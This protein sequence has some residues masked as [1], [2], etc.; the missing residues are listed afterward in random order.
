MCGIAGIWWREGADELSPSI[1]R[2]TDAIAHRG[3]D[4]D[5]FW[6]DATRGLAFGHRR[7]SIL[8]LSAAGAQPMRSASGRYVITFNGEIYNFEAIRAELDKSFRF[9]WSGGSDT[10]VMLAAIEAWG[11]EKAL[12]RF[13][14]MFAFGLWDAERRQLHLVRDRFGV[15]PLYVAELDNGIA[16][17]SELKA[18]R[19][20][21]SFA[22]TTDPDAISRYFDRSV[23]PAPRT[24]YANAK[25]LMPGTI[26]TFVGPR[27]EARTTTT[28]WSAEEVARSGVANLMKGADGEVVER[29]EIALREAVE[30]RL[31]SDVPL[32][33]FLSGGIDSSLVVALMQ[34]A[35]AKRVRTFSIGYSDATYDEGEDAARV[36]AHLGTDHTAFTLSP[37][38][39]LAVV[40]KLASMYDEPF[41]DS[42]QIPTHLVSALARKHVTVALSGD[43]GDEV[44]GGYNRHIWGPRLWSAMRGVPEAWRSK[45]S[46]AMKGLKTNDLQRVF[47]AAMPFLPKAL[48]VRVAGD[49]VRKVAAVLGATSPE[50]IY[51]ILTAYGRIAESPLT[52]CR[53]VEGDPLPMMPNIEDLFMLSDVLDALPDDILTKVDR[54]SM[55]VSLE[56]REPLLDHRLYALA[57]RLPLRMKIRDGRGK[58]V[59]R[60]VLDR[61]VPRSL[62]DRPKMGFGVPIGAWLRGPLRAWAEERLSEEA[63]RADGVF[64]VPR[65]RGYWLEHLDGRRDRTHSLWDILMFVEWR[66]LERST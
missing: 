15:K 43:G 13:V 30:A 40:P 6:I 21:K 31:V 22:R 50:H 39:A 28:Y 27:A 62:V 48:R 42:S 5:G 57:W 64:D 36:A 55:A 8:D 38:D 46:S 34:R 19:T 24:I 63:L 2:M 4:A 7:L 44:F 33:A 52:D 60:E 61:Y 32:G 14:G 11:L 49:K 37:E 23:I 1:Q 16:F 41:A 47:D 56:A 35:Q 26:A 10:E 58:W 45:A 59:L 3:P 25:K 9:G 51:R 18:L 17:A 53:V 29:V 12:E 66:A 20:L 54:A 65:V